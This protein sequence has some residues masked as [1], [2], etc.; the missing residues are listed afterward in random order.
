MDEVTSFAG[1]VGLDHAADLARFA[2]LELELS[3]V[4]LGAY[5]SALELQK[6]SQAELAMGEG[7]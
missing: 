4:S 3:E 6:K 2:L 5:V 1:D 7:D